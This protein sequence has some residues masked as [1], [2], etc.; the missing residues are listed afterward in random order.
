MPVCSEKGL[1]I[2][3]KSWKITFG[4]WEAIALLELKGDRFNS[5]LV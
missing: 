4:E 2:L 3:I 1:A 5:K